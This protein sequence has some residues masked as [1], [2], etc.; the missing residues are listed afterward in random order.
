MLN[1]HWLT[2]WT[3]STFLLLLRTEPRGRAFCKELSCRR[4]LHQARCAIVSLIPAPPQRTR[5]KPC[6]KTAGW[7]SLR[8]AALRLYYKMW[9]GTMQT[10]GH[11]SPELHLRPSKQ[12]SVGAS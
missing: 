6:C 2:C 9:T 4:V 11:F 1:S 10:A 8:T 5:V 3:L 12:A 7:V